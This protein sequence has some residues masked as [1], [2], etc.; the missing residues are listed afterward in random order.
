[1]VFDIQRFSIHDGPGIRTTVFLKGCPLRC[2]WCSN[3]E[4][5]RTEPELFHNPSRCL[6]CGLCAPVCAQS[7]GAWSEPASAAAR[8]AACSAC[9]ACEEV[10]PGGALVRKG[11]AMTAAEVLRLVSR[12][13]PIYSRTSGGVTFSGG[14]PLMQAG[15]LRELL[16]AFRSADIP[17]TLETSACADWEDIRRVLPLLEHVLVDLK[18]SDSTV[19]REWTG[20]GLERIRPNI[21]SI[22]REHASAR[23]RI[24]VIPGFNSDPAAGEGFARFAS[25][26]GAEVELLPY[27]NFGEGKYRMLGR[28][29][30]GAGID[31]AAAAGAAEELRLCLVRRGIAT[32]I[33]N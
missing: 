15:F 16:T 19:H 31:A 24:P 21:E 8:R 25:K 22:F 29:Y 28:E 20:V 3:P 14:E 9:G 11:S 13:L 27:H 17:A 18:H 5:Q 26:L 32:S 10:C 12:D 6:A 7:G 2:R 30:P 4:S 23:L 33:Y 1:M